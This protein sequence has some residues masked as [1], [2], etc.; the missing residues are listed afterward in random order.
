[1]NKCDRPT[2]SPIRA[3]RRTGERAIPPGLAGRLAAG[4]RPGIFRGVFDRRDRQ[5]HLFER[6]PGGAYQAPVRVTSLDDPAVRAK[7]DDST[8]TPR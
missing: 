8:A 6:V 2:R 7:L 4:Q 5:V 1:M 3:A